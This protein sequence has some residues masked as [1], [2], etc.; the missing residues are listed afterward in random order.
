MKKE[1]IEPLEKNK[2]TKT[3]PKDT[4]GCCGG[5]PA[6]DADACCKLDEE[7]KSEGESGCGCSTS[8]EKET[9]SSCC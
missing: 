1:T 4:S 8:E 3:E 6:N 9:K 7:K 5:T 2:I